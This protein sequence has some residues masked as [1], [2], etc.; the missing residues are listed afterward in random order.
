MTEDDQVGLIEELKKVWC[1]LQ[2][3]RL[4][5]EDLKKRKI[6]T[7]PLPLAR[8]ISLFKGVVQGEGTSMSNHKAR[9]CEAATQSQCRGCDCISDNNAGK[10]DFTYTTTA[11]G[12]STATGESAVRREIA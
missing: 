8:A 6:T 4:V 2:R 11:T 9:V 10:N 3:F 5:R 1:L 12:A 7:K